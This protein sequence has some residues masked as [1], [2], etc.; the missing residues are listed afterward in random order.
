MFWGRRLKK[1]VNCYALPPPKK[2]KISRT[3]ASYNCFCSV[4][5]SK[6]KFP[7]RLDTHFIFVRCFLKNKK[8][9]SDCRLNYWKTRV[10]LVKPAYTDIAHVKFVPESCVPVNTVS[11]SE[12][13][14]TLKHS[15]VLNIWAKFGERMFTHFWDDIAISCRSISFWITLY[16]VCN[17]WPY[18]TTA[19]L[20]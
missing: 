5:L 6:T 2:K 10:T 16:A 3:A 15:Y 8:I 20:V 4:G 17:D 12:V 19:C 13:I 1:V 18:Q 9:V 14:S 11:S 7:R